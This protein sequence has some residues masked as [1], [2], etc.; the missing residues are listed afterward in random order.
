[1]DKG[2]NGELGAA[3]RSSLVWLGFVISILFSFFLQGCHKP[4]GHEFEEFINGK[5]L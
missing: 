4:C 3:T 1:M 5:F 2:G